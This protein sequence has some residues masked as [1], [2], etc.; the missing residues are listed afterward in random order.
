MCGG[1]G[2]VKVSSEQIEQ[3]D[4]LATRGHLKFH[5][6]MIVLTHLYEPFVLAKNQL[7]YCEA[8]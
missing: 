7:G 3:L 8:I 5:V 1:R 6:N 2:G 4:Y